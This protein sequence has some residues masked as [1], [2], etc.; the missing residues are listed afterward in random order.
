MIDE[1]DDA[2][3]AVNLRQY[4]D[5]MGPEIDTAAKVSESGMFPC[6]AY[7]GMAWKS[8]SMS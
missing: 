4:Q 3:G 1:I 5:R 6:E 8:P 2:V 7:T